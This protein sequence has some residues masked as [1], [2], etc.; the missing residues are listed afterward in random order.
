[1]A[2]KI[3]WRNPKTQPRAGIDFDLEEFYRGMRL[4]IVRSANADVIFQIDRDQGSRR[5][6]ALNLSEIR[7]RMSGK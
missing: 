5:I 6:T 1:M 2:L 4:C 7:G 3:V